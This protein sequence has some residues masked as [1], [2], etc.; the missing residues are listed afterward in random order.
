[1][2]YWQERTVFVT[3]GGSGI[4]QATALKFAEAG[5]HVAILGRTEAKLDATI[6]EVAD[7]SRIRK[8][9][10]DVTDE[11]KALGAVQ[12]AFQW[13]GRLDA[14]INVAGIFPSEDVFQSDRTYWDSLLNTNLRGTFLVA[15]AA[16]EIM[17]KAGGGAIVNT[18]SVLAQVADPTLVTY[19]ATKGAIISL[20]IAMAVRFAEYN[21]RVNVVS[22]ADVATPFLEQWINEH[23]DPEAIRKQILSAYPLGYYCEPRDVANVIY[24]LAGPDARCITGENI[25]V[26]SG[27]TKTCY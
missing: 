25:V 5:A 22:P 27:L 6:R 26:D 12:E 9:P 8:F 15:R 14:A 17:K 16:A 24:F 23:D 19:S 1:M 21:I 2:D 7:P 13:K 20:T 18:S 3:G 10:V 4:G 11:K